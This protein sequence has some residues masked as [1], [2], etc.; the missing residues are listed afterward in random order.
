MKKSNRDNPFTEEEKEKL[1]KCPSGKRILDEVIMPKIRKEAESDPGVKAEVEN[2][3]WRV[4]YFQGRRIILKNLNYKEHPTQ[5]IKV[6]QFTLRDSGVKLI[7]EIMK[8]DRKEKDTK[9]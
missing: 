3:D 1:R 4:T 2:E 7:E 8:D 6:M 9:K 5:H